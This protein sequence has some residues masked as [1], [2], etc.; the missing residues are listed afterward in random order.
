VVARFD[1]A[2][3]GGPWIFSALCGSCS[4]AGFDPERCSNLKRIASVH[5]PKFSFVDFV[6]RQDSGA[7]MVIAESN[8]PLI[9]RL[10]G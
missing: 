8:R 6:L 3:L 7:V 9:S 10:L 4:A 1:L 2:G 5:F